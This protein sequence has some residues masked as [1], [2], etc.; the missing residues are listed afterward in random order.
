M[1]YDLTNFKIALQAATPAPDV[2]RKL[3]NL[4]IAKK[5]ST[6]A[7]KSASKGVKPLVRPELDL[8]KER[9]KCC[10]IFQPSNCGRH[11]GAGHIRFDRDLSQ[12]FDVVP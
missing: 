10:D 9:Q 7:K 11:L 12:Y 6:N 5:I 2:T 4:T 1:S 3:A 8:L